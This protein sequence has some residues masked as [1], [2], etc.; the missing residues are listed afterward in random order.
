MAHEFKVGDR[1]KAIAACDKDDIFIGHVGT[2]LRVSSSPLS[3]YVGFDDTVDKLL[4]FNSEWYCEPESLILE[5]GENTM[6]TAQELRNLKLTDSERVLREAGFKDSEGNW[7]T[8]G[9]NA[10]L[11]KVGADQEDSIVADLKAIEKAK[12]AKK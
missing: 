8:E 10:I 9:K 4:G 12:A 3:V 5:N 7:T 1:V 2:V 6:S 11:D